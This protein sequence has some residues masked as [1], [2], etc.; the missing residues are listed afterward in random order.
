MLPIGDA[1]A[2]RLVYFHNHGNPGAGLYFPDKWDH[3]RAQFSPNG[4][5]VPQPL[6]PAALKPLPAEGY[7]RVTKAFYCCEKECMRFEPEAFLQL[8]YNGAGKPLLFVPELAFG[9]ISVPDRGTFIDDVALVNLVALAIP[10]RKGE[11]I[12]L[13][14]GI[15]VH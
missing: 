7:Y 13:P 15:V 9:Q 2:G 3:N 4:M 12:S 6:D 11:N 8:G 1:E 14:R 5:T 10:E